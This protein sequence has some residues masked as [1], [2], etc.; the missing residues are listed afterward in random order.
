MEARAAAQERVDRISAQ[1]EALREEE[2]NL[3]IAIRDN[4]QA[5]RAAQSEVEEALAALENPEAAEGALVA[6]TDLQ[7]ELTAAE[8][9]VLQLE[10]DLAALDAELASAAEVTNAQEGTPT[11]DP[12]VSS[13]PISEES[14]REAIEADQEAAIQQALSSGQPVSYQNSQGLTVTLSV[15][16]VDGV[17][18]VTDPSGDVMSV[19]WDGAATDEVGVV[20]RAIDY[21]TQIPQTLQ[22]PSLRVIVHTGDTNLEDPL[23]GEWADGAIHFYNS[24][25][26]ESGTYYTAEDNVNERV[27]THEYGHVIGESLQGPRDTFTNVLD[28]TGLNV[29]ADFSFS[30]GHGDTR[31]SPTDYGDD[32]WAGE[33]AL[34]FRTSHEAFAEHWT[35]YN[36]AVDQGPA[37]LNAYRATYPNESAWFDR[38]FPEAAADRDALYPPPITVTPEAAPTAPSATATQP[39]GG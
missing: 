31:H 30:Y 7:A 5:L 8:A 19:E 12:S 1:L 37:A 33:G 17:Y 14:D 18:R 36:E 13:V 2:R 23:A 21:W 25:N 27:F 9:E 34:S 3:E 15:T 4:E 22:Q 20:A 26:Q 39:A 10:A 38:H 16:L 24:K 29:P 6:P 35:L 11:P 32:F 28:S